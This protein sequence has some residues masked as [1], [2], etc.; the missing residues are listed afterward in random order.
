MSL[1]A[2]PATHRAAFAA[3]CAERLVPNYA[4][5]VEETGW[6]ETQRLRAALDAVWRYLSEPDTVPPSDLRSH[7][8]AVD[9]VI[10]DTEEFDTPLASSALDAGVAVLGATAACYDPDVRHAASASQSATDTV[11]MYIQE[12]LDPSSSGM[13]FEAQVASHPFMQ[14]E[15]ARQAEDLSMLQQ[16]GKLDH[17]VLE[18]LR[19]R[20]WNAGV[21]NIGL[22]PARAP[23]RGAERDVRPGS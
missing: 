22:G 7:Y 20:S 18:K 16:A 9:E 10:P 13:D 11:D 5:F 21:S 2:L 4:A 17:V 1:D 19:L 14:R 6:G 8:V 3:S 23:E 15:S 12:L